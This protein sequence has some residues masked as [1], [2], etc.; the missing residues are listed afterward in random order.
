MAIKS[1]IELEISN[2]WS[3]YDESSSAACVITEGT[4]LENIAGAISGYLG[5]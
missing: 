4:S 5:T 3:M 2:Y 1:N